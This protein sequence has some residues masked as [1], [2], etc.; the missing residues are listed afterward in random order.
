MNRIRAA[1]FA[2]LACLLAA[3]ASP[4]YSRQGADRAV[5]MADY[6]DC[7][8]KGCLDHFTPESKASVNK[9]A[10]ACMKARG[11]QEAMRL[12]W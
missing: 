5:A 8:S 9:S 1:A 3:C 2:V 11:Y 7:Y 10:R 4:P 12:A 6:Q